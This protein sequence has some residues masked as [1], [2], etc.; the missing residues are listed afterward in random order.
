[1]ILPDH[2]PPPEPVL[3]KFSELNVGDTVKITSS[4]LSDCKS[5]R[6][7]FLV[8]KVDG[9][10]QGLVSLSAL[11]CTILDPRADRVWEKVDVRVVVEER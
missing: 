2:Q 10:S 1:M 11:P 4:E 3:F 6:T 7:I 9:L 8:V 5:I